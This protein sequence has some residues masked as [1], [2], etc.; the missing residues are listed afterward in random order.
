L[1]EAGT[2]FLV[3]FSDFAVRLKLFDRLLIGPGRSEPPLHHY[4][5]VYE[6]FGAEAVNK[7]RKGMQSQTGA[8]IMRPRE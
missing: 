4:G 8:V 2:R 6:R 1:Y 5:A 3:W 7:L